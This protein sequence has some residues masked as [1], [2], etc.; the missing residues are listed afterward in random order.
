MGSDRLLLTIGHSTHP[1]EEF[2]ELLAQHRVTAIADV[3]SMP[4]SRW[5]PQFNRSALEHELRRHNIPYVFLGK[6]L[7]A[8]SDD[9]SCYV[10]GRVQYRRLAETSLFREGIER[11]RTGSERERIAVMCAEGEPLECHRM[12]LVSRELEAAGVHVEHILG[13]GRLEPHDETLRRLKRLVKV[14]EQDMFRSPD[15]LEDLAY[16][17]Q[18]QRIAYVLPSS[19][20]EE[21]GAH[22]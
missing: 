20:A 17:K 10:E 19:V 15:E 5:Q 4:S 13:D 6:E 7:G 14:P 8:R 11:L 3:R 12:V 18:E 22:Q 1:I 21:A 16:Q 9:P 2:L